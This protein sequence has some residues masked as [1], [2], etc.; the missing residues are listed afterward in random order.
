MLKGISPI[1]SPQ[2][3]ICLMEMGHG[4]E[5]L[6]CDGNYP[7]FGCP[8][9]RIRMNGHGITE[10]LDAV[11]SLMPLDTYVEYPTT[12][13]E[14][15]PDDPYVPRIWDSYREIGSK[16]EPLGL[17][18]QAIQKAE[19]Y[20]KGKTCYACIIT[21]ETALYANVILKKGVIQY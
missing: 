9:N 4:D 18:E 3:M 5:L 10:I 16:H 21:S 19:F 1:I 20:P 8:A 17:R 11:L 6:I 2:L 12:F 7:K 14:V 15:L 13:M